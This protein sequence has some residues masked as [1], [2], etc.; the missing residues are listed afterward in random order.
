MLPLLGWPM[1]STLPAGGLS[2]LAGDQPLAAGAGDLL[3][4]P[5]GLLHA[6]GT[7]P[8]PWP[9]RSYRPARAPS[10]SGSSASSTRSRRDR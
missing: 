4:V 2:L 5:P 3:V 10:C 8:P 7:R 1:P 6:V 9:N